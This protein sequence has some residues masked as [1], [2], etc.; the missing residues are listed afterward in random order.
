[1]TTQS[2]QKIDQSSEAIDK[3]HLT[4]GHTTQAKYEDFKWIHVHLMQRQ[5]IKC[6][7]SELT[8]QTI[9]FVYI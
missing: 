1:M 2:Q 8:H 7:Y 9:L 6:I 3:N 5:H 4:I